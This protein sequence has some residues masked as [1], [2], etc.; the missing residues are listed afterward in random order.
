MRRTWPLR[1]GASSFWLSFLAYLSSALHSAWPCHFSSA[2]DVFETIWRAFALQPLFVAVE[3]GCTTWA[4]I[5]GKSWPLVV[6]GKMRSSSTHA[7]QYADAFFPSDSAIS[8]RKGRS[9]HDHPK[10]DPPKRL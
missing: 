4:D 10:K 8:G 6:E 9:D 2:S 1:G 5:D 7:R 3:V